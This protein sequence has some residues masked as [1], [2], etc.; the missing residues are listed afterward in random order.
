M[1]A[2]AWRVCA[3]GRCVFSM[4]KTASAREESNSFELF[5]AP[6]VF[7]TKSQRAPAILALLQVCKCKIIH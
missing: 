2:Y 7:E 4:S 6:K 3:F 5:R 1:F